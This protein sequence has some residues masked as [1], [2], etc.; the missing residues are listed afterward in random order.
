MFSVRRLIKQI[1]YG[2]LFLALLAL[3]VFGGWQIFKP[4]ASCF[5]GV[6]NQGE[7]GV[8]CGGPCV[9]CVLK[10]AQPLLTR[11]AEIFSAGEKR[12]I[13]LYEVINPNA[14]L[15]IENLPYTIKLLDQENQELAEIN[16]TTFIYPERPKF[17]VEVINGI[18]AEEVKKVGIDF[19][20]TISSWQEDFTS[21]SF[22]ID[23]VSNIIQND[24]VVVRGTL[25]N[26]NDFALKDA[27]IVVILANDLGVRLAAVKSNLGTRAP[28]SD[29]EFEIVVPIK[30]VNL[31]GAGVQVYGEARK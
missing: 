28:F 4:T 25:K 30:G 27:N 15:G 31:E 9:S 20:Y 22:S 17:I 24:K 21:P 19:E 8:D 13:V 2:L 7:E 18:S 10:N 12:L 5:D 14:T 26:S 23:D 16:G 1:I 3:I 11:P 6:L 29:K